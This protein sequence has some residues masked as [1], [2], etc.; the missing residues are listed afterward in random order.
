MAKD[1]TCSRCLEIIHSK[2]PMSVS[3]PC[4]LYGGIVF[5]RVRWS[6]IGAW[7]KARYGAA[8]PGEATPCYSREA[9]VLTFVPLGPC[10]FRRIF[11]IAAVFIIRD[12]ACHG[13]RT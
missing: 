7:L 6:K 11:D 9:G 10:R 1:W 3:A 4:P 12:R 5:D 2:K 13:H 8:L